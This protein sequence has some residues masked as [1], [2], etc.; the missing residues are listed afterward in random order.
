MTE[1]YRMKVRQGDS[2]RDIGRMIIENSETGFCTLEM[3][4]QTI[5]VIERKKQGE[6]WSPDNAEHLHDDL[7]DKA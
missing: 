6:R 3:L 4:P 1:I 7:D 2:Y 5:I